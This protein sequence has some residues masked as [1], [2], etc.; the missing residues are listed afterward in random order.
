M[1]RYDLDASEETDGSAV[2]CDGPRE[3]L[4]TPREV[5]L[6]GVRGMHVTRALPQR[7]LPM[8]G[9]W[10]F[11][12]RFGPQE[13]LMRVDPHPHIG[14]QTVTWPLTGA[15][16]HRDILGSDVIIG[17]GTLNIMTSGH[18]ISHS[19]Y[20]VGEEPAPIDALQ[21]WVALPEHR[22]HGTPDFQR[23]DH[24]PMLD[25]PADLG[26]D[27]EITV[28]AGELGGVRSPAD[29]HT[30]IVGAQIRIAPGS[31]VRLPFHPEWEYAVVALDGDIAVE[32]GAEGQPYP[33]RT[34]DLL[35]LGLHRTG[36][37]VSSREGALIFLLGGAPFDDEII[38]WWNFVG[39]THEEI[40]EARDAWEARDTD[41]YGIVPGTHNTERIPA[42]PLPK[43]RLT[44][45]RRSE[46]PPHTRR[47]PGITG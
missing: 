47:S 31:R 14:L 32:A 37:E 12:D 45:R 9:A 33:L 2:A 26:P 30:P 34:M 4:L 40:V 22:R 15:V 19:E 1:T 3:L 28:V 10:C 21:L 16:R 5:P 25:L 17:P 43:V 44:K 42:P 7:H 39:R 46:L 11:L 23:Y 24:L 38:M 29:M 27:P 20:S 41:R 13:A 35:Y 8:V 36:V 6:G 18:G